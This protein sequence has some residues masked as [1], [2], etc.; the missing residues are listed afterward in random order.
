MTG[1][2][3]HTPRKPLADIAVGARS[4]AVTPLAS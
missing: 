1:T 3:N 4:R 2:T